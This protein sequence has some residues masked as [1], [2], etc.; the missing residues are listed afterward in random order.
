[1][2]NL[3]NISGSQSIVNNEMCVYSQKLLSAWES[4]TGIRNIP[5]YNYRASS[6]CFRSFLL[7]SDK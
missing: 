1:M 5:L 3:Q 7:A 2:E 4:T 6:I